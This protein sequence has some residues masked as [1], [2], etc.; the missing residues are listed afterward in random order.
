M[1]QD[2]NN[3]NIDKNFKLM[4]LSAIVLV[5]LFSY[6]IYKSSTNIQGVR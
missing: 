1:K 4:V 5:V 2:L 6:T 3:K